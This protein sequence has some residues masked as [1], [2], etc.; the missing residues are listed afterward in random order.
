MIVLLSKFKKSQTVVQYSLMVF[1]I[2]VMICIYSFVVS[3]QAVDREYL[4]HDNLEKGTSV[5]TCDDWHVEFQHVKNSLSEQIFNISIQNL[6]DTKRDFNLTQILEPLSYSVDKADMQLY[7]WEGVLTNFTDYKEINVTI[8]QNCSDDGNMTVDGCSYNITQQ[9]ENG[10]HEEY[11]MGWHESK[12]KLTNERT[13]FELKQN[14][15]L[16]SF[17]RIGGQAEIIAY[18]GDHFILNILKRIATFFK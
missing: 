15:S 14:K 12:S 4:G 11:V 1:M 10:S 6:Q 2:F 8:E 5:N 18:T 7:V 13:D 17:I 3:A 9:V 16:R